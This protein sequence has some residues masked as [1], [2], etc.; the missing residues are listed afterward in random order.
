MMKEFYYWVNY[1]FN[2]IVQYSKSYN[3]I[4]KRIYLIKLIK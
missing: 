1:S 2:N 4:E 3:T